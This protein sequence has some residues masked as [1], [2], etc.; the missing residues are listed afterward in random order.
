MTS[1]PQK[2]RKRKPQAKVREKRGQDKL[3]NNAENVR[4]NGIPK[5]IGLVGWCWGSQESALHSSHCLS[6]LC[7]EREG[8]LCGW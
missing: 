3:T 8:A 5:L 7:C 1:R 4:T 2:A 6:C